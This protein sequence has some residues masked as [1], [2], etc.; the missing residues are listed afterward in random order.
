MRHQCRACGHLAVRCVPLQPPA[1]IG[2]LD[3]SREQH[4]PV[5]AIIF[6]VHYNAQRTKCS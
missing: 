2:R 1:L 3:R 5:R 6:N 4:R